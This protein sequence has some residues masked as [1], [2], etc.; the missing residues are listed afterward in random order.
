MT[1]PAWYVNEH[2]RYP[3][4]IT[5]FLQTHLH[6]LGGH[7]SATYSV[8]QSPAGTYVAVGST[9]G[10]LSLWDT[11]NWYCA[12]TVT[13]NASGIRDISFSFDGSY[14]VAGNGTDVKEG[15]KGLAISHTDT[16]DHVHTVETTLPIHS[17]AWHP[18]RYWL[19]YAGD[20]GGL[21]IIGPG[22]GL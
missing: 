20:A 1:G 7:S 6:S 15:E 19:A 8:A 14:V 5:D 21:R 16:G 9:D 3:V 12:H 2:F 11:Y 4:Q 22:T 13:S 10:I 17:V 18:Y